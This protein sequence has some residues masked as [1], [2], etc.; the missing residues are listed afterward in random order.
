MEDL[1][2]TQ[3]GQP[4]TTS[5]DIAQLYGKAHK[6]VLRHIRNNTDRFIKN[7]GK[8]SFVLTTYKSERGRNEPIYCV[9]SKELESYF[10]HIWSNNSRKDRV[11]DCTDI[12]CTMDMEDLSNID[13][14]E[15]ISSLDIANITGKSH[16]N[17]MQSIRNMENAWVECNGLKFQLVK[18]RDSK[19][20]ER[21]CYA[22]NKTE[23]LYVATK[24]NDVARAK[25]I[26][27]WEQ[28]EKEKSSKMI[29]KPNS[30]LDVLQGMLDSLKEQDMR[31]LKLEQKFED[32]EEERKVA[33]ENLLTNQYLSK[34][35]APIA[36]PRENSRRLVNEYS[37][38][39]GIR[40]QDVWHDVY[41][42]L[43]YQYGINLNA[44][45]KV[46]PGKSKLEIAEKVGAI[47]KVHAIISTMVYNYNK[48]ALQ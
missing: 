16:K 5:L 25:L 29:A 31:V 22:L 36:T 9:I 2:I 20:E 14:T 24:F 34:E 26:L 17:V 27:R 28:L 33:T 41:A 37:K 39:T 23:C 38:A 42:K 8:D 13:A 30:A 48:E 1:V 10:S 46:Y 6:S 45:E 40:Q 19:G 32:M 15:K 43:Y 18:Y 4:V 47:E 12:K 7:Y 35:F 44:Q 3:N 11:E 21:P